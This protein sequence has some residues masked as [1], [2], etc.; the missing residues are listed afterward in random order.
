MCSIPGL[1]T[2]GAEVPVLITRVNLNPTCGFVELWVNMDDERKHIYEQMREEIQTPHRKFSGSEG[3]PGDLCLVCISQTWHRARIISIESETYNVFL[4]DQGQPRVVTNEVLAWAQSDSFLLPPETECCILANVMS[5][6]KNW[7]D[8]AVKFLMSLPEKKFEGLVQQV[9]M[10]DRIILLD[11]PVV[12][13]HMCKSGVAKKVPV[14]E[15]K[16]FV[17]KWLH[18]HKD[19][20]SEAL[21]ET[22]EQN[23]NVSSQH[24]KHNQY[25]YPELLTDTLET[26][27]ITEVTDPENIFCKLLIFSK[28]VKILSEQIHQHYKES[29]DFGEELPQSCRDPCAAKGTDGRWHRSLLKQN[30]ETC[31]GAVEVLHVDEGKND[32]VPVEDIRPL[33]GKFMRMPVVTYLCSLNG[34]KENGSEWTAE[35]MDFLKSLLNKTVVVRFDRHDVLQDIYYVTLF[36][37]NAACIN[38]CFLE[39]AGF[40]SPSETEQDLIVQNEPIAS[41]CLGLL[42]DEQ[43]VNLQN[44]VNVIADGLPEETVLSSGNKAVD[45][46]QECASPH[47]NDICMKASFEHLDPAIDC[48]GYPAPG[49]SSELQNACDDDAFTV[50]SSVNV[51]VSCIESLHKFWCQTTKNEDS[52]RCL[53][54]DLQNHYSSIHHQPLV[55]SICVARNPDNDMW[56][57]ARIIANSH[58]P[59]VDVRFIDYGQTHKVPLRDVHPIDPAFLWLNAQAFQCCLFSLKSPTNPTATSWTSDALTEFHKFVDLSASSDFGLKCVVK[60][61]A[62]DEEGLP[63]NMVDIETVSGSACEFLA[64]K[65]VQSEVHVQPPPQVTSDVRKRIEKMKQNKMSSIIQQADQHHSNNSTE[66]HLAQES[67]LMKTAG[68]NGVHSND[69]MCATDD[70]KRS[71]KFT[72]DVSAP[73]TEHVTVLDKGIKPALHVTLEDKTIRQS[74]TSVQICY[75]DSERTQYSH[76]CPEENLTILM[77]KWPNISQKQIE[78]VYASCIVGPHYFWCQYNTEDLN[79]ISMLAQETGQPIFPEMLVPGNPCLAL[80]SSDNKWYRAQVIQKADSILSVLFIDYG[81]ESEVD[82]KDVMSMPQ[83]LLEIPPQA[84]LCFLNGFDESKGSWDDEVYDDFYNLVVDKPLKVMVFNE[85]NHS[86]VAV[87]QYAVNIECDKMLINTLVQKHWKSFSVENSKNESD[88]T[89]SFPQSIQTDFDAAKGNGNT[90]M[91]KEP[92]LSQNDTQ[93]VYASCIVDPFYFWCQYAN[94]EDLCKVAQ[95]AQEAGQAQQDMMLHETLGPGSPCL[96]LYSSDNQW[97]RAQVIAKAESTLRVLFIDYGNESEVDIRNVR[98]LSQTLLDKAPRAFLCCVNGFKESEGSWDDT[99]YDEFYS[100]VIDKP[101]KLTVINIGHHSEIA[102]PQYHVEIE[103][104]GVTMNT[105]M[106]KYWNPL[107]EESVG[108]EKHQTENLLHNAQTEPSVTQVCPSKGN[109]FNFMYKE[110]RLSRNDSEMVY[111]SCVVGPHFFWCQ[112]ANTEDLC[113]VAQLAQE[114]GQAQQDLFTETLG[115]GSPCLAL[116]S[117]DNQWYRA[118]VIE[119]VDSTLHILFIDYGNESEF[120]IRNIRSLPHT[121][122]DKAPQAFLCCL[123]GFKESEGSWDD[124]VYDEFY[125]LVID[126]PLKLKVISIGEHSEITLPQYHVEIECEGVAVNTLMQKYWKHLDSDGALAETLDSVDQDETRATH[127]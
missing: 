88:Q 21:D 78:E 118:Q 54:Q 29:T 36:A 90:C 14:E 98:P 92:Q 2:P 93:M 94:T 7:P 52:L 60:D 119:K 58:S 82:I 113:K 71:S 12:S 19:E 79:I 83:S 123:S 18:L 32:L 108:P 75:S 81:N 103:S 27:D 74:E 37:A 31:D 55:E 56:Y 99:I 65:C 40:S 69:T 51:K 95:L 4:I 107:T 114:A 96:A 104:E 47:T 116:Y 28:A 109:V 77:Y 64:K 35:Q 33:L 89:K 13:K 23:L 53:M 62:S 110:P 126:K 124:T 100:L 121:L 101:L 3:K 42:G 24:A 30:I 76:P 68:Q 9:L 5:L 10:P 11:I 43:Y 87:P 44:K 66:G 20:S 1:P 38:S 17:L 59:L 39:K 80:F 127:E 41:S 72:A 85:E 34:I 115:P 102:V 46:G 57:R 84:F 26:A 106:Q 63:L 112:Y 105:L 97:Y 15:F 6:E 49:L 125:S 45:S 16:N 50:G 67:V 122:L 25:F 70:L 73:Q 117:S 111:V 8:R 61:V 120:D 22:Q 48:D 86:K 91:Y